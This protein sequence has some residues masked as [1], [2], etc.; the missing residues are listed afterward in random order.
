MTKTYLT[1]EV[2]EPPTRSI[3][4]EKLVMAPCREACPA[5]VDVP[6]YIRYIRQGLYEEA[7]A[8]NRERIPFP[9]ICSY[10]C[11]NPCEVKCAMN[12][13]GEPVA[14]R[15][16]KRVAAEEGGDLWKKRKTIASPSGKKIAVVG[17]GPCGLTTAYY[18]ATLGHQVTLFDSEPK[19][20]G[21]MRYGIPRYRLPE[22]IIDRNIKDILN[23]GVNFKP[24]KIL[25]KNITLEGLQKEFDAVLI[26]TGATVS[27]KVDIEGI[28]LKGVVWGLDFLQGVADG[29]KLKMPRRVLTVG[30]GNVAIDVA[31]T[32]RRLGAQTVDIV[33]LE[34]REE[35]PAHEWELARAEEEGVTI[36]NSWGPARVIGNNLRVSGVE[37]KKCIEVFD[38]KG[39]FNPRYDEETK[40]VMDASQV[41]FAI[42]QV[43]DRT[44]LPANV[45][46]SG[47]A[48]TDQKGL[49]AAGDFVSG[50]TSIISSI[51]Q[52]RAAAV[53]IDRFLCGSGKIEEV[54]TASEKD[55]TIPATREIVTLRQPM[56]LLPVKER[57]RGFNPVELSYTPKRALMEA[58]RCLNCDAMLFQVTV[59]GDNCKA[60]GY[61]TE[62]CKMN[63]FE[64]AKYFNKRGVKPIEVQKTERCVGCLKCFY[65]C[66][67]FSIDI[68]EIPLS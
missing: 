59:Y 6:R 17:A 55:I 36:H 23:L 48:V 28:S 9:E 35:M 12:Q 11:F 51:A 26:A 25:G 38:Q 52:G 33:C 61:C 27:Q 29:K 20:G 63:V 53:E 40:V 43:P 8:V 56:P 42:G 15:A 65:V 37:F 66:P 41:I 50:S 68:K 34:K 46:K 22:E 1:K 3:P 32:A 13:F 47:S 4:R 64:P 2:N 39:K 16:L 30:G 31:L 58:R 60:C 54:L 21:T 24:E 18:L 14:I 44:L 7:L 67:D 49:F 19:A 62:V 10:A 5:G 45:L 57:M